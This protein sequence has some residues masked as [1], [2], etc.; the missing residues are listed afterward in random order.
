MWD[1]DSGETHRAT[2][3]GVTRDFHFTSFHQAIKPFGFILEVD[4]GSTFFLRINSTHLRGTLAEVEKAWRKHSPDKPFDYSFQDEQMASLHFSEERFQGLFT[5]FTVLAIAISC[6]GLFGLMTAVT[7]AKTKEIGIRKVLG[8]SVAG[9]VGL[10][11]KEFMKLIA[12]ALVVAMPLAYFVTDKW[13]QQF[14]YRIDLTWSIFVLTT[15]LT[16]TIAFLTVC[17]QS[18]KAALAN[19]VNSLRS[20]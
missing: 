12:M 8:S 16:F 19:P 14:A 2:I 6:L 20:E 13:L 7:E 4:N 17:L 1:D 10:L 5:A 3:V 9:V 15:V 18:T 11:T